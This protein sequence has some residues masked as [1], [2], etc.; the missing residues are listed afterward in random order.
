MPVAGHR[1][2]GTAFPAFKVTPQVAAPGALSAVYDCLVIVVPRSVLV[3]RAVQSELTTKTVAENCLAL[4]ADVVNRRHSFCTDRCGLLSQTS[5][6]P[7]S[8][9]V[10]VFWALQKRTAEAMIEMPSSTGASRRTTSSNN[11][12]LTSPTMA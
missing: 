2:H 4:T 10:C 9:C 12:R 3:D 11:R 1:T 8:V 5:H 6:V 7:W